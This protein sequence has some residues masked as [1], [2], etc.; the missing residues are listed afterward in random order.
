MKRL[1]N[2]TEERDIDF[3]E[4]QI[5]KTLIQDEVFK[6]FCDLLSHTKHEFERKAV[7]ERFGLMLQMK[8][9]KSTNLAADYDDFETKILSDLKSM[10]AIKNASYYIL[11]GVKHLNEAGN[12]SLKKKHYESAIKLFTKAIELDNEFGENAYY[13]RAFA[14]LQLYCIDNK[15]HKDEIQKAKNDMRESYKGIK[16]R[17]QELKYILLACGVKANNEY[18]SDQIHTKTMIYNIQKRSI[19][20]TIGMDQENYD[21]SLWMLDEKKKKLQ[22]ELEKQEQTNNG[23]G[24]IEVHKINTEIANVDEE[25]R[26]FLASNPKIGELDKILSSNDVL[27]IQQF[28]VIKSFPREFDTTSYKD[29]I[30]EFRSNGFRGKFKVSEKK[31]FQW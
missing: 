30:N 5:S 7:E 12:S 23:S 16:N 15:G 6:K 17:E 31:S 28:S 20:H 18:L 4:V 19:V 14:R 3:A 22:E 26:L 25:K 29:E 13:N 24:P 2:F 27:K 21:E 11:H 1:R 10:I 9:E 8:T